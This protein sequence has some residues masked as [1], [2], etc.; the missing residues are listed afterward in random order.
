MGAFF[1]VRRSVFEASAGFDERFL[2]Y[3]EDL[4]LRPRARLWLESVLSRV[5]TDLSSR[6]GNDR[7]VHDRRLFLLYSQFGFC[8]LEDIRP[9]WERS[10][11]CARRSS[12]RTVARIIASPRSTAD[13]VRAFWML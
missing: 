1:F 12:W 7:F 13:D 6:P 3:Y 10:R 8:M 11:W 5:R 4:D 9:R 2:V